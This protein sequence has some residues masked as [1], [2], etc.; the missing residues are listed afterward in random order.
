MQKPPWVADS[1]STSFTCRHSQR[2]FTRSPAWIASA[3]PPLKDPPAAQPPQALTR[4]RPGPPGRS[5]TPAVRRCAPAPP[6]GPPRPTPHPASDQ[7]AGA[8]EDLAGNDLASFANQF[9]TTIISSV[10]VSSLAKRYQ[11][12]I[13]SGTTA[14]NGRGNINANTITGNDANNILNG[15]LGNDILTA[16]DGFDIFRFN[17]T[18]NST[19]N[20]DLITDIVSGEDK[21]SFSRSIFSAF[22][23]RA[24]TIP[25]GQFPMELMPQPPT[26][27]LSDSYTTPIPRSCANTLMEVVREV[28]QSRSLCLGLQDSTP[29]FQPLISA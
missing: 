7:S 3:P 21:L 25:P 12:L 2:S 14:I 15:G 29:F 9:A 1:S 19:S 22:G 20:R 23:K 8:V 27:P 24:S 6:A 28:L 5:A 17:T 11:N 18:P 26:T 16:G 13:L 4:L 10:T